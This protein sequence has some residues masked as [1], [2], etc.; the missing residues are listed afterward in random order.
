[1]IETIEVK[2]NNKTYKYSKGITVQEI[3]TEHQQN[4]KYPVI[5]ARI[6]N[7]LRELS[8]NL[9]EDSKIEFLDLTSSE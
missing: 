4:Y 9:E 6:N 8:E 5:L 1:M 3:L 7:R 2:I